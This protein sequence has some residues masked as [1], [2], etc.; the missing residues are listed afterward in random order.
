VELTKENTLFG[1]I[2][3]E[4]ELEKKDIIVYTCPYCAFVYNLDKHLNLP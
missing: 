2:V 4:K 1:Q 3:D